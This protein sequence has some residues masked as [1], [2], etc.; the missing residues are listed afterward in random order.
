MPSRRAW[1]SGTKGRAFP[2]LRVLILKKGLQQT[3]V[4]Q[5]KSRGEAGGPGR[6]AS[7]GE[8]QGSF[9][10][11]Q[12]KVFYKDIGQNS[13]NFTKGFGSIRLCQR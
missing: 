13:R 10:A 2:N 4:A 6:L 3:L 12:G 11:P 5:G 8:G 1:L 7:A 9:Q